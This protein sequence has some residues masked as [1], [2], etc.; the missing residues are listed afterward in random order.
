MDEYDIEIEGLRE[1]ITDLLKIEKDLGGAFDALVSGGTDN[2]AIVLTHFSSKKLLRSSR[3]LEKHS[4]IL[5]RWTKTLE[6]TLA[7]L[8]YWRLPSS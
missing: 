3:R 7:F 1:E 4:E 2:L 8:D 5:N 6:I